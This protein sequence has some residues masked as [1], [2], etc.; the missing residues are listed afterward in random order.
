MAL[1]KSNQFWINHRYDNAQAIIRQIAK[2][3]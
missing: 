3:F 1:M 2:G